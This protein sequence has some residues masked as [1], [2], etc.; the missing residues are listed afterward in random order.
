MDD[1]EK[2]IYNEGKT[3]GERKRQNVT[4]NVIFTSSLMRI[5]QGNIWAGTQYGLGKYDRTV[6]KFT[7]YYAADGIGGNQFYDRSSCRLP[8][9]TLFLAVRT[10]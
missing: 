3:R 1:Y 5:A 4:Q 6:G 8:D 7:N 2:M 9:G 10:G